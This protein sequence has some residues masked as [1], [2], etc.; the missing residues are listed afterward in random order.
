MT[1]IRRLKKFL[2]NG[3]ILTITALLMNIIGISFNT[4]I[5]NKIGPDSKKQ[6]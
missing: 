4:Y 2:I 5:A 1:N 6:I 3:M